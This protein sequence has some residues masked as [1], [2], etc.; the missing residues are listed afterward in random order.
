MKYRYA[1]E[2]DVRKDKLHLDERNLDPGDMSIRSQISQP[3]I[4]ASFIANCNEIK[5]KLQDMRFSITNVTSFKD[6]LSIIVKECL[7]VTVDKLLELKGNVCTHVFHNGNLCGSSLHYEIFGRGT[8]K[9]M[10]W[11]CDKKHVG[12]WSSSEI[13]TTGHKI[14]VYYNDLLFTT[15]TLLSDNNWRKVSLLCKFLNLCTPVHKVFDRNQNLFVS[16]EISSIC[17]EFQQSIVS[18]FSDYNDV[19]LCGDGRNDSPGHCA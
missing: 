11:R 6:K 18:I 10:Q 8:V 4:D 13:L 9:V 3:M 16:P 14:P 19:V 15:C 17:K 5:S 12:K 7:I 1:T 2:E